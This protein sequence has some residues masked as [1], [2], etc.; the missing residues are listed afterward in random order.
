MTRVRRSGPLSPGVEPTI[1]GQALQMH[2]QINSLVC[3]GTGAHG[4]GRRVGAPATERQLKGWLA[5]PRYGERQIAKPSQGSNSAAGSN[6]AL[7]VQA[8]SV[9]TNCLQSICKPCTSGCFRAESR[10]TPSAFPMPRLQINLQ[11]NRPARPGI[12]FHA[13]GR[14]DTGW[15]ENGQGHRQLWAPGPARR[16]ASAACAG[17]PNRFPRK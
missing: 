9:P 2:L 12:S 11:I 5:T 7:S 15:Y 17:S 10:A 1:R 4:P 6:Q 16:G 8:R 14:R 3:T 13:T